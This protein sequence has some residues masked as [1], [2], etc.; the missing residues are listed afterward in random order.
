M[1]DLLKWL[2][3]PFV[4][5]VGWTLGAVGWVVGVVSGVMQVRSYFQQQRLEGA[6]RTLFEQA[7]RDW[8]ARYTEEQVRDLTSQ[9]EQL[10]SKITKDVPKEAKRVFLEDQLHALN[11][12]IGQSY[13]RYADLSRQLGER[14]ATSEL[15]LS[16]RQSIEV[17]IMPSYLER[18][19]RQHSLYWLTAAIFGLSLMS[20]FLPFVFVLF[21][22]SLYLTI[23]IG[24]IEYP[25]FILCIF[26]VLVLA[27][28]FLVRK[29][30][31]ASLDRWMQRRQVLFW[32][33]L[34]C[35]WVIT[36]PALFLFFVVSSGWRPGRGSPEWYWGLISTAL[37]AL[38]TTITLLL[39]FN[40]RLRKVFGGVRP[41]QSSG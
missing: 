28:G 30:Y 29:F 34:V 17:A 9:I 7:Q 15:P 23:H 4:Q 38:L 31:G 3:D 10:Q 14:D 6:Y 41:G 22:S 36:A 35:G 11:E 12:T 21:D 5:L 26:A 18:Q 33:S 16:I 39:T 1:D 20:F 13:E 24:N 40:P 8:E 25:I 19:R 37:V 2:Q 27:C 32:I